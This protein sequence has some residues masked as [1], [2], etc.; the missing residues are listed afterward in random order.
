[1]EWLRC[2]LLLVAAL[3]CYSVFAGYFN[4]WA[5]RVG[6]FAKT[7]VTDVHARTFAAWTA[8]TCAL[9]VLCASAPRSRPLYGATLASFAVALAHFLAE[10]ALYGTMTLAN[11]AAPGIVASVSIVWMVISWVY[12]GETVPEKSKQ[13][14]SL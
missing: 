9:C 13:T 6:V 11:L 8:V 4:P 1:M 5:L 2:W 14:K 12:Y 10:Y 7:E 3:R